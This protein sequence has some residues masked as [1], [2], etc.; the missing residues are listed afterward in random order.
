M[1]SFDFFLDFE[2][3]YMGVTESLPKK[4]QSMSKQTAPTIVSSKKGKSNFGNLESELFLEE[5]KRSKLEQEK[6]IAET[7]YYKCKAENALLKQQLLHA[8]IISLTSGQNES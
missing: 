6:L 3:V 8:Q 2:Y 4:T 1:T 5:I 7:F